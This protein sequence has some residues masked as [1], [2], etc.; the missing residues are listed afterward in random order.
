[1][2]GAAVCWICLDGEAD[3]TGKPIVRDC[4]CRGNDAGFAHMPCIIKYAQKQSEQASIEGIENFF[5]PWGTCPNCLQSYQ[6][7]LAVHSADAFVSFAKQTYDYPG[8]Q[9]EDKTKVMLALRQQIQSNLSAT[10]GGETKDAKDMIEN[11]IHKLLAMADKVKED[12]AMGE[13]VLMTAPAT[14]E[15]QMYKYIR[16]FEAYGYLNLAQLYAVDPSED[17]TQK[18]LT[19]ILGLGQYTTHLVTRLSQRQKKC[20]A[21]GPILWETRNTA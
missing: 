13:W 3:D 20:V 15:F 16:H 11:L 10:S 8:N 7:D 9:L 19:T 12:H 6:N 4:A 21:L 5:S 1:M 14:W 2:S 18:K 17:G